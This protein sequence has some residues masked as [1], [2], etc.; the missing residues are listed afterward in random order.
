MDA[1]EPS[2]ALEEHEIDEF[3]EF[4]TEK[5]WFGWGLNFLILAAGILAAAMMFAGRRLWPLYV[6]CTSVFYLTFWVMK[7]NLILD[8]F[9]EGYLTY[10][11]A[12]L[13]NDGIFLILEFF[14]HYLVLPIF[15]FVLI[16]YLLYYKPEQ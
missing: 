2:Q 3:I 14:L 8:P 7:Q 15:H 4:N 11:N 1:S 5:V 9:V 6:I 16:T 12:V 10:A 13:N